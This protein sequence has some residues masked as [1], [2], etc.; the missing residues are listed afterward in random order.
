MD[1]SRDIG[2]EE[3]TELI[4]EERRGRK[5]KR[6]KEEQLYERVLARLDLSRDIGDEELTELIH[7]V[8]QEEVQENYIPLQEQIALSRQLYH[9][10]RKLDIL[11]ELIED[12]SITEIMI[13]GTE[14]IFLERNGSVFKSEKRF[15]SQS[16]LS[17]IFYKN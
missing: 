17:W 8:L 13:N 4:H 14:D 2:D 12:D 1:L 9:S 5:A 7:D 3:L 10:F 16:K 6:V 15:L 11:Q